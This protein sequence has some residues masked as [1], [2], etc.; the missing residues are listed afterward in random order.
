MSDSKKILYIEDDSIDAKNFEIL[1]SKIDGVSVEIANSFVKAE[2]IDFIVT[3]CQVGHDLWDDKWAD[4]VGIPYV[5]L[6]NTPKEAYNQLVHSP[7]ALLEKP[8]SSDGRTIIID[9][10]SNLDETPNM[11]Y[12]EKISGGNHKLK[13]EL[14]QILESQLDESIITIPEL[15]K[16]KNIK[17]LKL[18]VHK[19]VSK[20]TILG[21]KHAHQMSLAIDLGLGQ[22]ILPPEIAIQQLL[23]NIRRGLDFLKTYKAENEVYHN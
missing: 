2:G 23:H 18:A 15:F 3:D 11:N 8:F 10:L 6:S 7:I 13:N 9:A 14:I 22:E 4:Y 21:M 12:A 17:D 20:F 16:Q 19:M 5:I 1:F